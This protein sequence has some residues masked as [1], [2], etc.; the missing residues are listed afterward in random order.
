ML[1][2]ALWVGIFLAVCVI[3]ATI[4]SAALGRPESLGFLR[5]TLTGLF[6][7]VIAQSLSPLHLRWW[8]V[9][10]ISLTK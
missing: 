2:V 9:S 1:F 7:I 3:L 10:L 4:V 6:G 8:W 5:L